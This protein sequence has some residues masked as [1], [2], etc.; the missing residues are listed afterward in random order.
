MQD[1]IRTAIKITSEQ[2]A[3]LFAIHMV[4]NALLM[5]LSVASGFNVWVIVVFAIISLVSCIGFVA[6][7]RECRQETTNQN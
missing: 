7:V 3:V 4:V 2:F 1:K 6:S 5:W